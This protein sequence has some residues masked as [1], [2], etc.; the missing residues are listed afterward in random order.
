MFKKKYF[1]TKHDFKTGFFFKL[2]LIFGLFLLSIFVIFILFSFVLN[3]SYTG[4]L[5]ELYLISKSS[6]IDSIGALS[7][8]FIAFG[9]II[10]FLHLQF[11]KLNEIAEDVE[12]MLKKEE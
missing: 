3:E 1:S 8:L 2:S 12:E 5:R 9:V 6:M 10:Y 4:F 7:L 11:V